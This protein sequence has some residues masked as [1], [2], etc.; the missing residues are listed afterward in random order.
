M[1]EYYLVVVLLLFVMAVG[2]LGYWR[3]WFSVTKKEGKVGVQIDPAKFKQ[4]KVAFSKSVGEK[5]RG[6]KDQVRNLWKKS[7]GW[8]DHDKTHVQKELAEL[9]KKHDRLE[10]RIKELED[11]DQHR[12]ESIKHDLSENLE[13]LEK[14]IEELTTRL[15]KRLDS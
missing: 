7:E 13:E 14:K 5:I 4:D 3:G 1:F 12:F 6:M 8:T 10:Q 2:A 9:E 11:A 15:E